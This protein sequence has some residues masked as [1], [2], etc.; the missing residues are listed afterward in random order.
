MVGASRKVV[1][2]AKVYFR[3]GDGLRLAG[4]LSRARPGNRVCIILCH[5]ITV[6]KEE[7]GIFTELA[8]KLVAAGFDVFRFDFR[9]HGESGGEDVEMTVSGEELDLEAA[10]RFLRGKGYARFGIV[11]ASFAGGA[12]SF[13]APRHQRQV[14]ALV[15]WN[16]LVNYGSAMWQRW[17]DGGN[18]ER[19]RTKGFIVRHGFKIGRGVIDELKRIKP[20]KELRKLDI[21]VLFVHGDRDASVPYAD[22]VRYSKMIGARL[23]TIKGGTHGFHDSKRQSTQADEAT[24]H[25]FLENLL[26]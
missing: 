8:R 9:G 24:I 14:R 22:S 17:L 16:A 11:A 6:D 7:D 12:V 2:M 15:M 3:T 13:F 18:A 23:E 25:F 21:P 19:L 26:G 1:D 5:G 10:Y 4:I 20:W